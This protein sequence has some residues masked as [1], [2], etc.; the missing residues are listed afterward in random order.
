MHFSATQLD[1]AAET[2]VVLLLAVGLCS[3]FLVPQGNKSNV[4]VMNSLYPKAT[5]A[6]LLLLLAMNICLTCSIKPPFFYYDCA[7]YTDGV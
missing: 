2:H 6:K 7:S 3:N 5:K 1:S 4:Y